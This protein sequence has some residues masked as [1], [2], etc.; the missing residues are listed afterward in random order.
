MT[1]S[2]FLQLRAI[3]Q[4]KNVTNPV[5]AAAILDRLPHFLTTSSICGQ[6]Y[7][8]RDKRKVGVFTELTEPQ[9]EG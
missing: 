4:P 1:D 6:S 3:G 8:L 2:A 5:L 9:K 7:R